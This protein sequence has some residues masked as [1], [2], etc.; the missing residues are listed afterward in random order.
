MT[1][2]HTAPANAA[3]TVGGHWRFRA[4]GQLRFPMGGQL[5]ISGT[6][7]APWPSAR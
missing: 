1:D 6:P 3:D 5:R 4:Y 7:S 2:N